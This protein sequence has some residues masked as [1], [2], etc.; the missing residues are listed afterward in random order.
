MDSAN[1]KVKEVVYECIP[2]HCVYKWPTPIP[3]DVVTFSGTV[4][5]AVNVQYY[6]KANRLYFRITQG[7]PGPYVF[8]P[9][10]FFSDYF[11]TDL[12]IE[13]DSSKITTYNGQAIA[14]DT[15]FHYTSAITTDFFE[16]NVNYLTPTFVLQNKFTL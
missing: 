14:A 6:K 16:N 15:V 1:F 3:V 5:Y 2:S 13:V 11:T 12:F 4:D 8:N 7:A 10:I 9:A